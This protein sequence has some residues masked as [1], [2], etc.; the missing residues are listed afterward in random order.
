MEDQ[1]INVSQ[2]KLRKSVVLKIVA[3][4]QIVIFIIAI[5]MYFINQQVSGILSLIGGFIFGNGP[6]MTIASLV[7]LF[8][9][10]ERSYTIGKYILIAC[11]AF[12][13]VFYGIGIAIFSKSW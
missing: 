5:P 4:I 3:I 1:V 13:V 12:N 6:I 2:L 8:S 9:K 11:L 10:K 7:I